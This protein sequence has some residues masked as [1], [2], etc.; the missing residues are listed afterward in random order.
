MCDILNVFRSL[1]NN[2]LYYVMFMWAPERVADAF[3][4]AN[5]D[6]N[7]YQVSIWTNRKYIPPYLEG[8]LSIEC[9][10]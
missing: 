7:K 10:T 5:G 4:V 3:A 8:L 9:R 1:T 6:P 2:V